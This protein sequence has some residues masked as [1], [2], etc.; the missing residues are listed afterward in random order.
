MR[1]HNTK[2]YPLIV[3]FL[4]YSG[5]R[6]VTGRIVFNEKDTNT[7]FIIAELKVNKNPIKINSNTR[8]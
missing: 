3:D 4:D 6:G 1:S 5:S 7:G 2:C 8:V